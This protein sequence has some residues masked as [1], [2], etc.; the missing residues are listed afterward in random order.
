MARQEQDREDLLRDATALVERVELTV[1]GYDAPVFVGFRRNGCASIY[2]SQDLAFH[3]NTQGHL[4]RA[5]AGGRLYKAERGRLVSMVRQRLDH[6]VQLLRSDVSDAESNDFLTS[7]RVHLTQIG[8]SLVDGKFVVVGQ[9][10]DEV[11]IVARAISWLQG[12]PSDM[13]IAESPRAQ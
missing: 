10:P 9:V 11:D 2:V 12:M 6:E 7:M 8:R 3:F 13:A 1:V 5:Y 4:R